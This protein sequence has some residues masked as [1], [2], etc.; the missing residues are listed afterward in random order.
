MSKLTKE[1]NKISLA[2]I[3]ISNIFSNALGFLYQRKREFARYISIGMTPKGIRKILWIE[4]ITIAGK[5]LLITVP[6]TALFVVFAVKA[7]YLNLAEFM[8]VLPIG[9]I[10]AF[11][12]FIFVFVG[13]AYYI[14]GKRL[15]R[16][17]LSEALRDDV[18]V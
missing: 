13:L 12:I 18:F 1:I 11:I 7:S 4:A 3:G 5:P 2:V 9:S 8:E 17:E 10:I 6:L 15:L 14:G 16:C